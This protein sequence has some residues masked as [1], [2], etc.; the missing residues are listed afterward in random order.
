MGKRN[1]CKLLI[2]QV[3]NAFL[4]PCKESKSDAGGWFWKIPFVWQSSIVNIQRERTW[5]R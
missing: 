1:S 2:S 4:R 5:V 3:T